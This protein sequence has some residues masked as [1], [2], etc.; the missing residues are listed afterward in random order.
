MDFW[1]FCYPSPITSN[2]WLANW[3]PQYENQVFSFTNLNSL[4]NH[5]VH[6]LPWTN[7]Q[8]NLRDRGNKRRSGT[9]GSN[10]MQVSCGHKNGASL[11][12][13]LVARYTPDTFQKAIAAES[14]PVTNN[15]CVQQF[16]RRR[17]SQFHRW[18][19]IKYVHTTSSNK[20]IT[21]KPKH[22]TRSRK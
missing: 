20:T 14:F 13:L 6:K 19:N 18:S 2:I 10:S 17:H 21:I 12:S 11:Y 5:T 1:I 22:P 9:K 7:Y 15:N 8:W 3:K 16:F 4:K